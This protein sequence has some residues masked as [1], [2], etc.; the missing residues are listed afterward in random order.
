[1]SFYKSGLEWL[2]QSFDCKQTPI[3]PLHAEKLAEAVLLYV[4]KITFPAS[5][6]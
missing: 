4:F 5:L 3:S 6:L 2:S 1:M